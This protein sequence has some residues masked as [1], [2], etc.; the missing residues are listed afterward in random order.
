MGRG[1]CIGG[2]GGGVIGSRDH[3]I[4]IHQSQINISPPGGTLVSSLVLS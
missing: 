2:G 1:V 3:V 4:N